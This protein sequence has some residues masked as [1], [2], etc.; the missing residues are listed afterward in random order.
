MNRT[1]RSL[2]LNPGSIFRLLLTVT[3]AASV[4]ACSGADKDETSPTERLKEAQHEFDGKHYET[5]SK[6]LEEIRVITV[7]TALGGEVQYLLAESNYRMSNY[8]EADSYFSAYMS[9]Y[10]GGPHA[11]DALYKRAMSNLKQIQY[12]S[13]GFKG[14]RKKIP[15][16]RDISLVRSA[17]LN[18]AQYLKEYPEGTHAGEASEWIKKLWEREGQHELEIASFYLKKKKKPEAALSRANR[19]LEG[20]YPEEIKRQAARLAEAAKEKLLPKDTG[21]EGNAP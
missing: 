2:P 20:E 1:E 16:D 3:L 5:A 7:G 13:I 18:F 8:L 10:P 19:I 14:I 11:E 12:T 4:F 6:I 15:Y 9:A 21:K 17:R